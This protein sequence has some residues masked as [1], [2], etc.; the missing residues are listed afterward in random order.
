MVDEASDALKKKGME[1]QDVFEKYAAGEH[2][3]YICS[4][5]LQS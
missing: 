4:F 5:L 2:C 1:I 3:L